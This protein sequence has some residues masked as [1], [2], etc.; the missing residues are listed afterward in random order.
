VRDTACPISTKG[1]RGGAGAGA[2]RSLR[3]GCARVEATAPIAS[4]TA[5][6]QMAPT[7]SKG[8]Q[9]SGRNL[10]QAAH[11][12]LEEARLRGEALAPA[13]RGAGDYV[14]NHIPHATYHI[15]HIA[16]H[17]SHIM[18]NTPL[19]QRSM[20]KCSGTAPCASSRGCAR[21]RHTGARGG[22]ARPFGFL[23]CEAR[24][25]VL[26]TGRRS[27]DEVGGRGE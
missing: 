1:W 26:R 9:Y 10:A 25:D 14:I 13:A 11:R 4:G 5:R 2:A 24:C 6:K 17:A 8:L 18:Y 15:L 27:A 20:A 23:Q 12:D 21:A 19:G 22:G 16:Y 3:R 7:T